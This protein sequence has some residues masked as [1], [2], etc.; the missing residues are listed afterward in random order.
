MRSNW[1]HFLEK[2]ALPVLS[3]AA[4]DVLKIR[5]PVYKER[6]EFQYLEAIGR[7]VCGIGP[8]LNLPSDGSDESVIREKYKRITLNAITNLVNPTAKD[9]VDFGNGYQA[10]VDSA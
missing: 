7:I 4:D 10:L 1:V 9:Y 2:I 5:M 3:A 8:W 6:R